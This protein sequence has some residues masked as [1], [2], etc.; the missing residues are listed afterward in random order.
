MV[1]DRMNHYYTL[2]LESLQDAYIGIDG[3]QKYTLSPPSFPYMYFK[4][5]GGGGSIETLSGT[6]DGI[7][8]AI[9]IRLYSKKSDVRNMANT[10]R[11]WAVEEGFHIDYFSPEDNI[12]DISINQFILRISKTDV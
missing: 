9:E 11:E 8:L 2:L 6:E 7:E 10:A 5:I 12:S 1:K 4:Q 3:S